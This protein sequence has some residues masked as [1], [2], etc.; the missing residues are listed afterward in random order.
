MFS[1]YLLS[2]LGAVLVLTIIDI[3]LPDSNI[4]KYIKS[5]GAVFLV[6]TICSPIVSIAKNGI[7]LDALFQDTQYQ[8]NDSCLYQSHMLEAN[9]LADSVEHMLDTQGYH[10]IEVTIQVL[11]NT[12]TMEISTIFADF[13][14]SVLSQNDAHIINYTEVK[15]LIAKYIGIEEDKIFLNV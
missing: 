8:L 14:E 4:S 9:Y 15:E 3:I 10:D 2:I 5:I 6:A 13:G 11:P 7:N 1:S 12:A